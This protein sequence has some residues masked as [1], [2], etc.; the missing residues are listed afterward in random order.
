[1]VTIR[2]SSSVA[3]TIAGLCAATLL[4]GCASASQSALPLAGANGAS[5]A[6]SGRAAAAEDGRH[7]R[8]GTLTIRIRIPKQRH[9]V[10]GSRYISAG[11]KAMTL[12]FTGPST[13]TQ[14]IG[15]TPG[16]PGCSTSTGPLV[17]TITVALV[18]GSYSATINTYDQGPVSGAIPAGAKLLSAAKNVALSVSSGIANTFGVT[19]DGVPASLAITGL[20]SGSVGTAFG[21]APFTVSVK[22]A[23]SYTIVGTYA[24]PVTLSNSDQSGATALATT[25]SDN[26]IGEML[27]SGDAVTLTYTGAAIP[28][29]TISAAATGATTGSA[30]L[31]PITPVFV[32]DSGNHAVKE[33]LLQNGLY[34]T[35]KTLG[36]GFSFSIPTGVAADRS[37]N[38]FVADLGN[39]AVY[40]ILAQGGSVKPLGGGFTFTSPTGVA[41]DGNGNVFVTDHNGVHEMPAPS[42]NT[43]K[44]I[45]TNGG[46]WYGVAV[47]GSGNVFVADPSHSAVTEIVAPTYIQVNQIGVNGG[48]SSPN[49]VGV[50][51]SGNVF[52]ADQNASLA[53]EIV[54]PTYTQVNTIGGVGFSAPVDVAVLLR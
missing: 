53:R 41:L 26:P 22:D 25:G 45:A 12:A 32:A 24:N 7:R 19:L 34:T 44:P 5:G 2:P 4:A 38:V 42:Y 14:V 3:V 30:T 8:K 23:D 16:S 50:D 29:A 54:A 36:N 18:A 40:E 28:A 13:F 9:H 39:S 33:I 15:L 51:G 21:P 31:A 1:M 35:V 27:S 6:A 20:P 43:V 10:R 37:G 49:G 52:V 17:C 46:Y 48:F 11:T 47:D